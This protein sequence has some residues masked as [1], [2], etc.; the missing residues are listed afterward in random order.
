[1]SP[2][3]APIRERLTAL[4]L[5]GVRDDKTFPLIFYRDNCADSAL[6]ESDIDEAF[7]ASA[8]AIVVTGTHFA[9]AGTPAAQ[10][11]LAIRYRQARTAAASPSTSTIG[12]TSGGSPVM[13]PARALHR[14]DAV[15]AICSRSCR[16]AI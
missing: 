9:A 5:L 3:C 6:D 2:A 12:P 10:Q 14:S 16:F 13:A 7:V 8:K 11:N 4:V 15:T 1:M